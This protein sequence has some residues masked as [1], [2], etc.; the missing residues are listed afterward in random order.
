MNAPQKDIVEKFAVRS[1][2]TFKDASLLETAL[3]H[4]SYLNETRASARALGTHRTHNERLE[5][6]GDAVLEL[7]V[8][9]Y[10]FRAFPESDE[11]TLTSYR[12]ALV[13]AVMLGGIAEGLGINEFL[14]LSKGESRDT[15]RARQTILANAFEA[16]VGAVYLDQGYEAAY[17]FIERHVLSKVDEMVKSG[18]W[19]DAKSEFQELAQAKYGLTPKYDTVSADGP[20]HDKRFV[21]SV[22]VGD[23][24]I[25][26]GEGKS[27]QEAEQEAAKKALTEEKK[28]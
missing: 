23:V 3:T 13:N 21:I 7:A 8:T 2:V 12:A 9:D 17:G 11:G 28:K 10:L 22:S 18:A 20:D 27:K 19:R 5:F 24:A 6:L 26:E 16:V 15:G 1:G 25:A 4:R 14:L